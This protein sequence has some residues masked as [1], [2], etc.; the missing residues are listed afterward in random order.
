M[1][2]HQILLIFDETLIEFNAYKQVK[3]F[4]YI[5]VINL[6]YPDE[7][8]LMKL[9][10]A[11]LISIFLRFLKYSTLEQIKLSKNNFISYYCYKYY[12]NSIKEIHDDFVRYNE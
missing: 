2:N 10:S 7:D 5:N 9:Y 1:T 6:K 3:P 12:K 11:I 4:K 8:N